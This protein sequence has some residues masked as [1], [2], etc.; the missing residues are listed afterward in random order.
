MWRGEGAGCWGRG[1][2][3]KHTGS[4]ARE[5]GLGVGRAWG[6][7]TGGCVGHDHGRRTGGRGRGGGGGYSTSDSEAGMGCMC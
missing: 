3:D 6:G 5:Q 4:R 7:G 1:V 2:G